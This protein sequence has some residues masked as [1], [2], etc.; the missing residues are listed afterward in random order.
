MQKCPYITN[1]NSLTKLE[2]YCCQNQMKS[3]ERI[4]KVQMN[5][6]YDGRDHCCGVMKTSK[7]MQPL[8]WDH[9]KTVKNVKNTEI[10]NARR[11]YDGWGHCWG[12]MNSAQHPRLP[13]CSV[14]DL[15][16]LVLTLPHLVLS[17]R[18]DIGIFPHKTQNKASSWR[19]AIKDQTWS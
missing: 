15:Q 12:V 6:Q 14:A 13:P 19:C 11:R 3:V 7:A 1:L 17:E 8:Q 2:K 16:P 18:I 10:P 9:R 4:W 5:R